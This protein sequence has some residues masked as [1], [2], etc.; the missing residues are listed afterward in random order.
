VRSLAPVLPP[1]PG[2]AERARPDGVRQP[3]ARQPTGEL[4]ANHLAR[5]GVCVKEV[6]STD[7]METVKKMVEIG[8]GLSFLPEMAIRSLNCP[9]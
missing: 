3:L 2:Q 4:V 9:G 8:L 5:L 6:A 7:N 1:R